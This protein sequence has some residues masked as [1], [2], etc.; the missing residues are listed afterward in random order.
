MIQKLAT[1]NFFKDQVKSIIFLKVLNQLNNVRVA[2][3]VME[4]VNL[5]EDP[6][7]AVGGHLLNNL[8]RVLHLGVDVDAGLD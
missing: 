1:R 2:L 8:D 5:L 6:G 7:S 3:T 4:Q